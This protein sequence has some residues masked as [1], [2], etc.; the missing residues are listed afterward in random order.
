[1]TFAHPDPEER[2]FITRVNARLPDGAKVTT[3]R[4]ADDSPMAAGKPHGLIMQVGGKRKTVTSE[5]PFCHASED[6]IVAIVTE[7]L[8]GLRQG[9]RWTTDERFA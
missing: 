6:D 3:F 1:V 7:W 8:A 4:L 5:S 2:D 9:E